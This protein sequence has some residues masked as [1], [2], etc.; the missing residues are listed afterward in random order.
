MASQRHTFA[1]PLPKIAAALLAQSELIPRARVIAE[2]VA[3]LLP[4]AAAVVYVVRDQKD[5]AWTAKATAG[6]ITVGKITNLNAGTL[7]IVAESR[8]LQVFEG[9]DL[10]REAFSHLDV[11]RTVVSLAYV[12]LLV[13]ETL[14]GA[15]ELVC[16]AES[17]PDAALQS[18]NEIAALASPAIATALNYENERNV[19]LHSISRVTQMYDLE[20]VF[21]S[22][23]EMDELLERVAKK[24]PELMKVQGINL[25]MVSGD[26]VELVSQAG[27]DA[28]VSW[29]QSRG[30]ETVSRE[31]S[32]TPLSPC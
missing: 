6:E 24:M 12:P 3:E 8:D 2:W 31:I 28:T 19:S 5:P 1:V 18:L 7:G 23:L 27:F 4:D 11:R 29:A 14:V 13:Y 30:P 25:W 15:I 21:N 17:P 16:Y 10:Q 9:A 20:K 26:A 32:H 22:T